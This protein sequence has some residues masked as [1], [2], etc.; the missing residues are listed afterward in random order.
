[1]L[2][3]HPIGKLQAGKPGLS[4]PKNHNPEGQ[5]ARL[6]PLRAGAV[7]SGLA[8]NRFPSRALGLPFCGGFGSILAA[9]GVT[10][11]CRKGGRLGAPASVEIAKQTLMAG[12]LLLAIGTAT[13]LLAQ[14]L[15]IPDVA[16]FLIVGMLIGPQALGLIDIRADSAVNQIV[17]LFGAS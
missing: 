9:S 10:I 17:L 5:L 12:G 14:R 11:D 7:P 13:G 3:F 8:A 1:M 15:R 16:V 6:R 4:A 2:L